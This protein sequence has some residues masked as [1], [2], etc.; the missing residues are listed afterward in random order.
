MLVLPF[1]GGIFL[2]LKGTVCHYVVAA[3]LISCSPHLIANWLRGN[4]SPSYSQKKSLLLAGDLLSSTPTVL[5]QSLTTFLLLYWLL[6]WKRRKKRRKETRLF[7]VVIAAAQ[8]VK[9]CHLFF[10]KKKKAKHEV[11]H[12]SSPCLNTHCTLC[13]CENV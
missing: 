9:S 2:S 11:D 5:P 8:V 3:L 1:V 4:V 12:F 13:H 7:A 10:K 6:F